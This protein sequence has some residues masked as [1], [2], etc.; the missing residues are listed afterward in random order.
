M[1]P[2]H[3][4]AT[5]L[6]LHSEA[7]VPPLLLMLTLRRPLTA[8][9]VKGVFWAEPVSNFLGGTACFVTMYLTRYRTLGKEA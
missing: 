5:A 1:I 7:T 3:L 4:V 2:L 9:G 8:L 6:Q